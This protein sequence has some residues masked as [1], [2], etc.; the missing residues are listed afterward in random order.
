MH[1]PWPI[2][3]SPVGPLIHSLEQANAEGWIGH[4][5]HSQ[6]DTRWA[7]IHAAQLGITISGIL[8]P[9]AAVLRGVPRFRVHVR[10]HRLA[11]W[12]EREVADRIDQLPDE[13]VVAWGGPIGA[14][15]ADAISVNRITGR[16]TLWDA[17]YRS[18]AVSL[19]MS[20]TF[21]EP[22]RWNSAIA[23]AIDD[24]NADSTLSKKIRNKALANLE[25]RKMRIITVGAGKARN[26]ATGGDYGP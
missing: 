25:R 15:G 19:R 8:R 11:A 23:R 10:T 21:T 20:R 16:V 17:K 22:D 18:G 7:I 4:I 1:V 6:I 24:L 9:S 26:S 13:H 2:G 3:S 12:A 14:H 5:H